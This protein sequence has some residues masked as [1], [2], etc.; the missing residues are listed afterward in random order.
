MGCLVLY[1][2]LDSYMK[3][4]SAKGGSLIYDLQLIRK[5]MVRTGRSSCFIRDMVPFKS[6]AMFITLFQLP[7]FMLCFGITWIPIVGILFPSPLLILIG[8]ST[9]SL[10]SSNLFMCR[11][12]MQL[13]MKELRQGAPR[14]LLMYIRRYETCSNLI[15]YPILS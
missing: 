15:L 1:F 3:I 10:N 13:N 9:S 12:W 11:S 6:I 5:K 7:Y 8:D 14:I 2:S 4:K